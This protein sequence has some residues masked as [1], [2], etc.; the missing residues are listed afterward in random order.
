MDRKRQVNGREHGVVQPFAKN[1]Y[2]EDCI[3]ETTRLETW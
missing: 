3:N 1:G 2:A